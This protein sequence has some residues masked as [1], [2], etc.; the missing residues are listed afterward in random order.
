IVRTN[1]ARA[2]ARRLFEFR[3]PV[4]RVA[5]A[6]VFP[7]L[8]AFWEMNP[9]HYVEMASDAAK[10]IA[11]RPPLAGPRVLLTGAPVDTHTLHETIESH[12]AVVVDEVGPRG[13][14]AAGDA[15]RSDDAP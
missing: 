7:L 5:G 9:G 12:G 10:R 15:V 14:R 3:R 6:E 8:G 13:S 1:A 2:A 11:A 4:P